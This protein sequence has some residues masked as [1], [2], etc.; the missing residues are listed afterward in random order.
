MK[1]A[2][3]QLAV[4]QDKKDNIARARDMLLRARDGGADM[5]ILPEMFCIAYSLDL[6]EPASEPLMGD[7][8][9]ML[10]ESA[11]ETGM[12]IV[13]GS[14]PEREA[15]R[16]YNTCTVFDGTGELI[17][18]YRKAHMFDV[19]LPDFKFTESSVLSCG[20]KSPL[21]FDSPI[22]TGVAICFD[23]RFPEF[24]RRI[25]EAGADLYALPA[26]F[27]QKT[28]VKHWELLLRARA[29]DNQMFVA[30]VAPAA[31]KN[32]YGHTMLASPDGAVMYC[33]GEDEGL[34]VIDL[35]MSL[36][37]EARN[38]IPIKTARRSELY[39]RE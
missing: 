4:G 31:S 32:S 13:G 29:L 36:L 20:N 39:T 22:K 26:A 6:F 14:F 30:G 37:D 34:S 25:M 18:A 21:I 2:L 24:G 35:P 27:A 10:S 33:A 9:A 1:L 15:G 28:G 19:F 3:I 17:G 12:T 11:K 16:I 5:A 38:S 8:C 7:C 23:I